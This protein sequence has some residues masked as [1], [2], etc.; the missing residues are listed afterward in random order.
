MR[1]VSTEYTVRGSQASR[2]AHRNRLL[3]DTEVHRSADLAPLPLHSEVI[4]DRANKKELPQLAPQEA[5]V[6]PGDV[7]RFV[8]A[9]GVRESPEVGWVHAHRP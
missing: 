6:L 9:A 5:G 4:F 3:A 8:I 2:D 1:S 7:Q